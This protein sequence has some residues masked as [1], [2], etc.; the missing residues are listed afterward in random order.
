MD[1]ERFD[2][3]TR[4]LA[5][6]MSRRQALKSLAGGA[7]GGL[8]AFL[9]VGKAAAAPPGCKRN[10]KKCKEDT[11]CCSGNCEN[12]TCVATPNSWSCFCTNGT[13]EFC[14]SQPCENISAF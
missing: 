7:A 9:G 13:I 14:S 5:T 8:L 4:A 11:Q 3:L 10:G 6:G 1:H 12:G 2:D